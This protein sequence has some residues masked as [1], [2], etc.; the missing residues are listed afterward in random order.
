MLKARAIF[1]LAFSMSRK[2]ELG[3]GEV[4]PSLDP[5]IES[6]LVEHQSVS[7]TLWP[8]IFLGDKSGQEAIIIRKI[9]RLTASKQI[10]TIYP[11]S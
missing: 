9:S 1:A 6:H 10:M 8:D 4:L 5:R 7:L 2:Y 11:V 3:A